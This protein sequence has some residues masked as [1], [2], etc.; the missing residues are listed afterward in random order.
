[1]SD[2]TQ[3]KKPTSPKIGGILQQNFST[4]G[5]AKTAKHSDVQDT[6]SLDAQTLEI[7]NVQ[8]TSIQGVQD[9]KR[10]DVH[11]TKRIR[12]TV[13]LE[14]ENDEYIREAINAGRKRI[15]KRVEISDIVN[16]ALRRMREHE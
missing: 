16:E 5:G 9:T 14:E 11:K 6:S 3:E 8:D 4:F 7:K 12:Q 10:S 1:M 13:Y 15:G 2:E